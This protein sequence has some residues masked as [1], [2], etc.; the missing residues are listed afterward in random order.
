MLESRI[1]RRRPHRNDA[2]SPDLM[3]SNTVVRLTESSRWASFILTAIGSSDTGLTGTGFA[4]R[5]STGSPANGT[6]ALSW[7]GQT[8]GRLDRKNDTVTSHTKFHTDGAQTCAGWNRP[9]CRWKFQMG[10]LALKVKAGA[11][12]NFGQCNFSLPLIWC[13]WPKKRPE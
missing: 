9:R 4:R 3:R 10:C 5:R 13:G 12:K 1:S 2:I 8:R 11:R 6:V 7:L